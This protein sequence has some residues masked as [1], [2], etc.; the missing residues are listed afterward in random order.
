MV[1]VLLDLCQ[2]LHQVHFLLTWLE[3]FLLDVV[4]YQQEGVYSSFESFSSL[5]LDSRQLLECRTFALLIS[6]AFG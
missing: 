4:L 3:V 6:L 5:A 1:A 2:L